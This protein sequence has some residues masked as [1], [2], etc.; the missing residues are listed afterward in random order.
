MTSS[1]KALGRTV[2][3]ITIVLLVLAVGYLW[4]NSDSE[5]TEAPQVTGQAPDAKTETVE[6]PYQP[7]VPT[8]ADTGSYQPPVPAEVGTGSLER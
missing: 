3:I 4:V 8:S 1:W 6:H 5:D 2:E 7:P